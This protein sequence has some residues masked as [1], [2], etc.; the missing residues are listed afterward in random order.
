MDRDYRAMAKDI[1]LTIDKDKGDDVNKVPIEIARTR[2]I[3]YFMAAVVTASIG[4]GWSI[5]QKAHIS[6]PLVMTFICGF[7]NNGI[8]N[9]SMIPLFNCFY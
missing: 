3:W 8:Y 4:F 9:V 2:S 6:V 7:C 5:D 1:G